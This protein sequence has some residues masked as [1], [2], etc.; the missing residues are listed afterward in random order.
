MFVAF[1]SFLDPSGTA[2]PF[3]SNKRRDVTAI[4]LPW[5]SERVKSN[6]ESVAFGT[7]VCVP[8]SAG[9]GVTAI[10]LDMRQAD[11]AMPLA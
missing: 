10:T 5:Y 2:K 1:D 3:F 8:A 7:V 9:Y 4:G 11:D 6:A